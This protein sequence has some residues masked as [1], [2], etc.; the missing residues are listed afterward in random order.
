MN[1][2]GHT[3]DDDNMIEQTYQFYFEV[4]GPENLECSIN[5]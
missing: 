1:N 4:D 5:N 2:S 3:F